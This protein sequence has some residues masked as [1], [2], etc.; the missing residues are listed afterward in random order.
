MRVADIEAAESPEEVARHIRFL[1]RTGFDRFETR[2]KRKDGS[3]FDVEVSASYVRATNQVMIFARDITE[4]KKSREERLR[5]AAAVEQ[6]S[7]AI[8]LTDADD[9]IIY[10]NRAFLRLHAAGR[11]DV[12]GRKYEDLI[13]VDIED[14]AFRKRLH[15]MRRHGEMW[16][17]RLTRRMSDG[18]ERKMEVSLSAV[19]DAAGGIINYAAIESDVTQEH[20]LELYVRQ[21]QKV[22]AL[23]TLAG[24]IAHD[25]N[26]ILVPI[27]LNTELA[28][29]DASKGSPLFSYLSLVL[30][31]TNR[32]RE[33]VRQIISFSRQKEQKRGP[34]D[35]VRVVREGLKLLRSSTPASI[36]LSERILTEKAFVRGDPTQ[37]HQVVMNIGGNATYA[38]RE[39]GGELE[40][41]LSEVIIDSETAARNPDLRPGPYVK[42]TMRD[43]G[44]GMTPEVMSKAFDP[45]F[46][47]KKPGEGSG[48]GL[49]VVLGIVKSHG[50]AIS[51][52]SEPEKGTT[53][54]IFLPQTEEPSPH[55]APAAGPVEPGKGR[56]LF[57][58]DEDI[59]QRTVPAALRHLGY[60]VTAVT[61]AREALGLF[62]KNADEFDIVITDQ[63][64]PR[65]TGEKLAL[66][67][68][69]LRPGFPILLCTGFSEVI[70]EDDAKSLGIAG[71]ILKPFSIAEIAEKIQSLL[72]K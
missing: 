54:F 6:A 46:T 49:A 10:I 39:A 72:K 9:T 37:I 1:T 64:M 70:R 5:L 53:F 12:L 18:V 51:A 2:H 33:L 36:T 50:G 59:L 13:R 65:M 38:M 28:L 27:F 32:G 3:V 55:A 58:D 69:R 60:T 68:L 7:E 52:A 30:E 40:V 48:M 19:R 14:E 42:L 44:T 23:G 66:E 11:G 67:M 71:F 20:N 47:T 15:H 35:I 4:F 43:T 31:A 16:K 29:L 63:T 21:L 56:I 57:V 61:D 8:A 25:F 17:A 62:R 24:G 45:F 41:G 34:V 26:N 22:E